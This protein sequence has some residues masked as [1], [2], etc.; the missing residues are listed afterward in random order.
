MNYPKI[1]AHLSV[2]RKNIE[3]IK[4]ICDQGNIRPMWVVKACTSIPECVKIYEEFQ[5]EYLATS[6]M[7]QVK[8]MVEGGIKAPIAL[9]RIPMIS[10]VED[11][12][13]YC[14]LSL[15]SD[16]DVLR[17]LNEEAV[18]QGKIHKV[19]LMT[20]LGDLREGFYLLDELMSAATEVERKMPGL[21]LEGIGTNLGCYGAVKATKEK[22]EQLAEY[23]G[24]VEM[25]I[26]RK[27]EIVSGG[28]T[29]SLP[30]ILENEM[31][32]KVN[33][34]RIGEAVLVARDLQEIYNYDF[35]D[36]K[37]EVFTMEMEVIEVKDKPTYPV[38]EILTDGFGLEGQYVDR[39][40]RK[41]ALLGGGKLDYAFPE[42][43]IPLEPGMEIVG[44]S[45]DHTIVDV[46]DCQRQ[47][48]PG[49]IVEFQLS[50]ANLAYGTHSKD[51]SIEIV[52]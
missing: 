44:A 48:K 6:R 24:Y 30:R 43:L 42:M 10:E 1:K 36:V 9:I 32:A 31:P 22:M 13:K 52:E 40:I 11:T 47:L 29:T 17:A 33:S 5:P 38:G 14:D 46:Q 41:R 8:T 35:E 45:S 50:Y 49:D 15:N 19:I 7:S 34:L 37:P 51:V 2:L 16:L 4:R 3:G 25:V 21:H 18:K 27:L 23:A 28:G 39:G 12:I 20:D 26:G